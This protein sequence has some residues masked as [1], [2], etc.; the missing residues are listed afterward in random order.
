MATSSKCELLTAN[1]CIRSWFEWYEFFLAAWD[2]S[3]VVQVLAEDKSNAAVRYAAIYKNLSLFISKLDEHMHKL[4]KSQKEF[5]ELVIIN[6]Q[7]TSG[8][9]TSFSI[10]DRIS[11]N[12][13]NARNDIFMP[14][15]FFLRSLRRIGST[16]TPVKDN[17]PDGFDTMYWKSSVASYFDETGSKSGDSYKLDHKLQKQSRERLE[18]VNFL[19][20]KFISYPFSTKPN[21]YFMP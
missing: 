7:I 5:I 8:Q 4:L 2:R 17:H 15:Y 6:K 13:P 11:L 9:V 14:S 16:S 20:I 1:S 10:F 12:P 19:N 21:Q 3:T 18:I